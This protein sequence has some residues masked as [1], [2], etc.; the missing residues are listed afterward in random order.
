[1][2]K[3]AEG[4][5]QKAVMFRGVVRGFIH[6]IMMNDGGEPIPNTKCNITFQDGQ[7]LV[8]KTDGEGV[9]KFPSKAPGKVEIELLEDKARKNNGDGD[10]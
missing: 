8:A 4:I 9:L 10:V 5:A 2:S 7:T 6:I 1:M 3:S